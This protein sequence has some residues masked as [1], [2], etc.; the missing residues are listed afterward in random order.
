MRVGACST[1]IEIDKVSHRC[2]VSAENRIVEVDV[3]GVLMVVSTSGCLLPRRIPEPRKH[4]I[5]LALLRER[6][7][8]VT[9]D[10]GWASRKFPSSRT[11]ER[12][13]T[14]VRVW[15]GTYRQH[16]MWVWAD[17]I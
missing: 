8:K 12:D 17:F 15:V 14:A 9:S 11:S 4:V 13:D 6:I 1:P 2:Q 3:P 10:K 7:D 5:L 16:A